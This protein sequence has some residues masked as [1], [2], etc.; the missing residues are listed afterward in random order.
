VT[1][2]VALATGSDSG[3]ARNERQYVYH[4]AR[5]VNLLVGLGQINL[6]FH[7]SLHMLHY[8]ENISTR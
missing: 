3:Q 8:I 5:T 2:P 7:E 6:L 1:V 4:P